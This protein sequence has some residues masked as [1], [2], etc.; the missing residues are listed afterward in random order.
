LSRI[1]GFRTWAKDYV[2]QLTRLDA[3]A[4]K[5]LA[6]TLGRASELLSS[7]PRE[8]QVLDRPLFDAVVELS[9]LLQYYPPEPPRRSYDVYFVAYA[10]VIVVNP[11]DPRVFMA[12]IVTKWDKGRRCRESGRAD[13]GIVCRGNERIAECKVEHAFTDRLS[14]RMSDEDARPAEVRKGDAVIVVRPVPDPSH[15]RLRERLRDFYSR[16]NAGAGAHEAGE[17]DPP[18]D[19]ATHSEPARSG[20]RTAPE[21]NRKEPAMSAHRMHAKEDH[22]EVRPSS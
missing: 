21:T 5:R 10:T 7:I 6:D 3:Q 19:P 8:P 12:D 20:V 4:K 1:A 17:A 16:R 9:A 13:E 14:F 22:R 11:K 18:R 15:Q 2:S